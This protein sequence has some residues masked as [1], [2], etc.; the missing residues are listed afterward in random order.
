M[1]GAIEGY[2]EAMRRLRDERL[3]PVHLRYWP[4]HDSEPRK[5]EQCQTQYE[6]GNEFAPVSILPR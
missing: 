5:G 1:L 2:R 3:K 4:N 6:N